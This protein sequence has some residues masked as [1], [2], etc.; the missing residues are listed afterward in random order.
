[1]LFLLTCSLGA[2]C[3]GVWNLCILFVFPLHSS[4][5][6]WKLGMDIRSTLSS[7]NSI[8]IWMVYWATAQVL[9]MINI[10]LKLVNKQ[11]LTIIKIFKSHI[12]DWPSSA[13]SVWP[14]YGFLLIARVT[15][16]R[17]LC[18]MTLPHGI[19][20]GQRGRP[21]PLGCRLQTQGVS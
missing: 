4:W 20:R 14:F 13:S 7:T 17:L 6:R 21:R 5:W 18:A 16:V 11:K 8:F 12:V 9:F 2:L 15:I 10:S 19:W 1:M 3:P